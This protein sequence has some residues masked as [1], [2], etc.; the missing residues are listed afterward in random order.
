MRRH[1]EAATDYEFS[2][3]SPH[4]A[5]VCSSR[6]GAGSIAAGAACL[7]S[8]L[9]GFAVPAASGQRS[10][11]SEPYTIMRNPLSSALRLRGV[12]QAGAQS[13]RI[14]LA[15]VILSSKQRVVKAIGRW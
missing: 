13:P 10:W 15:P 11:Q 7:P 2:S 8:L 4:A 9:V 5:E 12:R 14:P 1:I 3:R 6:N